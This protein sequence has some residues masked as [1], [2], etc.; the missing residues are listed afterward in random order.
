MKRDH[1]PSGTNGPTLLDLRHY[2]ST[3]APWSN[4]A[5]LNVA[6][7]TG[8]IGYYPLPPW[9]NWMCGP[10]HPLFI[11]PATGL[12]HEPLLPHDQLSIHPTSP[13]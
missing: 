9:C 7:Y 10:S 5:P 3:P 4:N 2:N 11:Y 6:I 13:K 12:F 1:F 8:K